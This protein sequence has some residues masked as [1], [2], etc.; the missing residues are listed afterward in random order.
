MGRLDEKSLKYINKFKK[1]KWKNLETK[2]KLLKHL[3]F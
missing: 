2:T 1:T 3:N